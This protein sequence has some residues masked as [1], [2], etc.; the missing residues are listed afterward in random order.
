MSRSSNGVPPILP[1]VAFVST[2]CAVLVSQRERIAAAPKALLG[3]LKKI[4]PIAPLF[5]NTKRPPPGKPPRIPNDEGESNDVNDDVND[6]QQ[7]ASSSSFASSSRQKTSRRP[8]PMNK[9][10]KHH[11]TLSKAEKMRIITSFP[12]LSLFQITSIIVDSEPIC[13][14]FFVFGCTDSYACNYDL[15]ATDDDGSCLYPEVGYDCFGDCID[16]ENQDGICDNEN[17]FL[18]NNNN[19]YILLSTN[20]KNDTKNLIHAIDTTKI[21]RIHD[22]CEA[23]GKL[24]IPSQTLNTPRV[25]VS[26]AK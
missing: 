26:N 23:P 15:L 6:D 8:P 19:D 25:S 14:N 4:F 2:T 13:F 22:I 10:P 24:F 16:D 18:L 5:P 9:N 20:S 12:T 3:K 21:N 17:L 1:A 7:K 11:T